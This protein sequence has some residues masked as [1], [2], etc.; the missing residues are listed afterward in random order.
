M[1]Y[2]IKKLPEWYEENNQVQAWTQVGWYTVK[3][4]PI[5]QSRIDDNKKAASNIAKWVW[6]TAWLLWTS[7]AIWKGSWNKTLFHRKQIQLRH[8]WLQGRNYLKAG[9]CTK[10]R[11]YPS[12]SK[13][14][15]KRNHKQMRVGL[16]I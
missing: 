9:G 10:Y 6:V 12:A 4:V 3:S 5:T 2:T 16:C 13:W 8:A 15:D 11:I 14:K 1:A 7:K